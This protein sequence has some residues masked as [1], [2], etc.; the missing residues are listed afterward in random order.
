MSEPDEIV[1]RGRFLTYQRTPRG[2]EYVTRTN[3]KG[4]VAI[5]AETDDQRI[6]LVEQH[7][8]PV[9]YEFL[10]GKNF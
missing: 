3:A 7:R 2:W 4:C 8:P 10:R 6:L 9:G 5:L 1:H